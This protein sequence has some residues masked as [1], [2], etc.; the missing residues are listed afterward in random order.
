M[1]DVAE[2]ARRLRDLHAGDGLLVVAN[3]WDAASA[4]VVESLGFPT[5]ATSSAA[6]AWAAGYADGERMPLADVVAAV[7]KIARAV[8]IPVSVDFEGGYLAESGGVEES[9]RAL[10]DAGAAG[11]NLDDGA[12]GDGAAEPVVAAET[13]AER[14]ELAR[15]ASERAL[16]GTPAFL[17]GRTELYVRGA[18]EDGERFEETVRRLSAYLAAGADCAFVPGLLDPV[19]L[20][21][22]VP[23]LGGPVNVMLLPGAPPLAE[24]RALGVRRAT[25]GVSPF[26]AA[27][28]GLERFAARLRDDPDAALAAAETPSGTAFGALARG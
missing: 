13:L 9:V 26:L 1:A 28:A 19:A 7:A 8:E 22:L 6:V 15:A 17:I 16:G 24:L 14:L 27:M 18:G 4:R 5:V 11:I 12:Y 3:A 23:R 20:R 10:L 25:T 21:E 2:R